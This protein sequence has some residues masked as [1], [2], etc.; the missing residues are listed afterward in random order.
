[1]TASHNARPRIVAGV[2]GSTPSIEALRWAVHQARL[3]GGTVDAVIAWEAAMPAGGLGLAPAS[4]LDDVDYAELAAKALSAAVA[5][6]SPPPGVQVYQLV[7]EGNASEVLLGAARN[8]NLLV[9]GHSGHGGFASALTGSVSIRCLHHASCPVVVVRGGD[10]EGIGIS[11]A[12][13]RPGL[14]ADVRVTALA[15]ADC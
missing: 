9:V 10:S 6:V 12:G 2:D 8:A 13:R 11:A 5:D 4:G 15:C 14:S 7:V 1:M 3:S